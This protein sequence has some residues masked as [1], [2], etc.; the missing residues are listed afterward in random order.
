MK[1]CIIGAGAMGGLYGGRLLLAGKDI[2]FIETRQAAVDALNNGSYLYDGIDGEHRLAAPAATSADG[3]PAADIAFIHTDTNNTRAAAEHAKAVLKPEGWAVT[4][5][6]GVGNVETLCEVL[7]AERVVG[8]ISYHSAASPEAGHATHTNANKTW[9]GELTGGGSARVEQ[10]RDLL[11]EAT[12][13]PHIA[14]D[15]LSVIWTKFMLNCAVNPLCAITGLRSG[16]VGADA[17]AAEMQELILDETL[18]VIAAKGISLMDPDPKASIKRILGRAFNKPSM[19][20]HMEAG[21]QTEI[22]SLNGAVVREGSALGIPTPYNHA[23]TMMIKARNA[24]MIRQIHEPAIDY[25]ALEAAVRA[26]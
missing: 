8:G 24:N 12:F 13:D 5:Q 23:L 19:L 10:L 22:D 15:I 6:N 7:G 21:L 3:L 18:A 26:E 14:E 4:F 20:Q 9:V 11:A 16:E 1:I 2:Q 17:A 25:A